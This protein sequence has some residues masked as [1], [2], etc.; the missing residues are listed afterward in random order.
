MPLDFVNIVPENNLRLPDALT[1]KHGPARL[2]SRFVLAADR[3]AR[4]KGILLRVRH[5][6]DELLRLNKYYVSRDLWYP[7]V[8]AFN[9]NC[10]ELTPENAFCLSD[11][12]ENDQV[13][14]SN[15]SRIYN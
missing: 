6:F 1:I 11:E 5:D 8:D 14:L 4:R 15:P 9:P 13:V 2:L 10:M 12:Y 7:L 3:A